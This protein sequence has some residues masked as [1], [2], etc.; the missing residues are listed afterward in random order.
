M[1]ASQS[2]RPELDEVLRHARAQADQARK[3]KEAVTGLRGTAESPDGRVKVECTADDPLATLLIDPRAM[4][5][6]SQ[7]L[8]EVIATV[9]LHARQDL[10]RRT[11]EV[12]TEIYGGA[13]PLE[14]FKA[15]EAMTE[16]LTEIRENMAKA[17]EDAIGLVRH[18]TEKMQR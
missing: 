17:S 10:E 6:G 5:L 9:A 13:D 4:R 3:L 15:R 7:E 11:N 16:A 12:T 1:M 18:F 14:L 2:A 8:A